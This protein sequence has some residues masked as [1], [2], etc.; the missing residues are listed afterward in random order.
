MAFFTQNKFNYTTGVPDGND[1][2]P[3]VS[4]T[5][6]DDGAGVLGN[7]TIAFPTAAGGAGQVL[8]DVGGTGVLTFAD[9]PSTPPSGILGSVQLSDGAGGF[10]SDQPSFNYNSTT[11]R[12]G[13][14]KVATTS[15]DVLE[16]SIGVNA[17]F[18]NVSGSDF[19]TA[20]GLKLK[21]RTTIDME[22]TFG[23]AQEFYLEDDTSGELLAG[24]VG[25]ERVDSD[26]ERRYVVKGGTNGTQEL[27]SIDSN[28]EFTVEKGLRNGFGVD[29]LSG[30]S[31][32][33]LAWNINDANAAAI[34]ANAGSGIGLRVIA[35]S[36]NILS[37]EDTNEVAQVLVS[38]TGLVT[39][40][41]AADST[42]DLEVLAQTTG[43]VLKTNVVLHA[44]T[45]GDGSTPTGVLTVKDNGSTLPSVLD[46]LAD[47][48]NVDILRL[49]NNSF[50][51]NMANGFKLKINNLGVFSI[52]HNTV[53][54]MDIDSSGNI[55]LFNTV[56]IQDQLN[57][58]KIVDNGS[59]KTAVVD[60]V[61]DNATVDV[62]RLSNAGFN[63]DVT[64][65][66]RIKIANGGQIQFYANNIQFNEIDQSGN[67]LFL[68]G[69]SVTFQTDVN[70]VFNA[71]STA[72]IDFTVK[73]SAGSSL[74]VD[75]DGGIVTINASASATGDFEVLAETTG[76]AAFIDVSKG[77]LGLGTNVT[78]PGT[79]NGRWITMLDADRNGIEMRR[80]GS[81]SDGSTIGQIL[82]TAPFVSGNSGIIG[83]ISI[84]TDGGT[85]TNRGGRVVLNVKED[86]TSNNHQLRLTQSGLVEIDRGLTLNVDG[87]SS[88]D[89]KIKGTSG[90]TIAFFDISKKGIGINTDIVNPSTFN[91]KWITMLDADRSGI[92]M[93]RNGS[94]TDLSTIGQF[95]GT[96]TQISGGSGIAGSFFIGTDGATA[97]NRGGRVGFSAKENGSNTF[98]SL[99]VRSTGIVEVDRGM[100]L[101][102]DANGA[103]DFEVLAETTGTALFVDVANKRLG[104]G[105][106]LPTGV[107]H[108]LSTEV[109]KFD[110]N[111]PNTNVSISTVQMQAISSGNMADGF[112]PSMFWSIQD[113]AGTERFIGEMGFIRNGADTE[114]KF[115]VKGGT[116]GTDSF[117]EI[118]KDANV[119]LYGTINP[120]NA[121]GTVASVFERTTS[122]TNN[123]REVLNVTHT[124][125]ATQV[126]GFGAAVRFLGEDT[127][128]VAN[129]LGKIG[130]VMDGAKDFGAL[131]IRGGQD[132]DTELIRADEVSGSTE[133]FL[134]LP[135][136][137]GT[138]GSLYNDSGTVKVA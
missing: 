4:S 82:A 39:F 127:G 42:G 78:N 118:D 58:I 92:E 15:L 28:R 38:N 122:D 125:S 91:G 129:I 109:V 9:A 123:L 73:S 108:T 124:T 45:I 76:T 19:D 126:D 72:A 110:R 107:I 111:T 46:V 2:Y 100:T 54:V 89:V 96:S 71:N 50:S 97:G 114:G 8:T 69:S 106:S 103:A 37:L 84:A 3:S 41:A 34:I 117:M 5:W 136:S 43:S 133:I 119:T 22:A 31:D 116:N 120:L 51:T 13:V 12:L 90:S 29:S 66:H 40:N 74:F 57:S 65:G 137:A 62:L 7:G 52:K 55:S 64:K 35:N 24:S 47:D 115:F 86:A 138:T 113:N 83:A 99:I 25:F 49:Q 20:V 75:G 63:T 53:S 132:G 16:D 131:I 134:N 60:V 94:D 18:E 88:A 11:K 56:E 101:N 80:T 33:A 48:Q 6:G 1:V 30:V 95:F 105:H 21:H 70:S 77:D 36:G 27:F 98:H 121:T 93:K 135:T 128:G 61:A 59:V 23:I 81:D 44:V 85:S 130:F 87:N 26:S 112:G 104:V 68:G 17:F 32:D 14:G 10:T 102:K 79:F 67:Q